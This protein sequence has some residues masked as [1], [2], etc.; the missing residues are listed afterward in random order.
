[1]TEQEKKVQGALGTM[2]RQMFVSSDWK[3]TEALIDDF[4]KALKNFGLYM[5]ID[6]DADDIYSIIVSNEKLTAKQADKLFDHEEEYE[7]E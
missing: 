1:M 3:D 4:E 5:Y 7:K 6:P 2:H